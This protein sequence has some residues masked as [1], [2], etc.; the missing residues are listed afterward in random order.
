MKKFL[1]LAAACFGLALSSW[2][3]FVYPRVCVCSFPRL[4]LWCYECKHFAYQ[5]PRHWPKNEF[6]QK[7]RPFC[8]SC[9]LSRYNLEKIVV[10]K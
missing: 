7:V 1:F 6:G 9:L 8:P 2:V 4:N 5:C 3:T 10:V